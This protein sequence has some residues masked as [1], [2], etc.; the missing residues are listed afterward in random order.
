MKAYLVAIILLSSLV[1][2]SCCQHVYETDPRIWVSYYSKRDIHVMQIRTEKG[3]LS[4]VVD[5]IYLWPISYNSQ[6][7]G[8]YDITVE[9][10]FIGDYEHILMLSGSSR[11]DTMTS[12]SHTRGKCNIM[13]EVAYLWNGEY[14][15]E[16]HRHIHLD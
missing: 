12:V 15:N 14:S 10:K 16:N 6:D 7:L 13:K 1:L 11:I 2:P 9:P 8:N 3:N 5:T 4:N